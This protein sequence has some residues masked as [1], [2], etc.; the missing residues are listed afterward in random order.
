MIKIVGSQTFSSVSAPV[1]Y[2]AIKAYTEDHTQYL[3]NSIKILKAAGN[4]VYQRLK[5]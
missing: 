2:A 4:Y 1:Q 5:A 3:N